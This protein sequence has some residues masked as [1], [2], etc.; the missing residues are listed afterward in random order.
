MNCFADTQ[1]NWKDDFEQR[2]KKAFVNSVSDI[3]NWKK[4][5][6]ILTNKT[7]NN[8]FNEFVTAKSCIQ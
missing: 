6:Y 3:I 7:K 5:I 8:C 1:V 2:K 4:L